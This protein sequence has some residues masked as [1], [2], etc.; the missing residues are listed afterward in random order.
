MSQR[1]NDPDNGWTRRAD[2][3]KAGLER[4]TRNDG[5]SACS[6]STEAACCD[7]TW[8]VL[9][10]GEGGIKGVALIQRMG[11]WFYSRHYDNISGFQSQALKNV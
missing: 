10:L 6:G 1:R 2:G 8:V 9:G 5:L 4:V 7:Y 11:P 3:G